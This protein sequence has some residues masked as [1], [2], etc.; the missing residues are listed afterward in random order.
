[1]D[2]KQITKVTQQL[3]AVIGEET[4]DKL[5][6]ETRYCEKKRLMTPLRM[7]L[8]VITCLGGRRVQF[9]ADLHR[10][11]NAL[12]GTD[13][14]Y[15]PFHN[16]LAKPSFPD[17]MK[18]V[19]QEAWTQWSRKVLSPA[20]EG[21]FSAFDQVVIQD[22]SSFAVKDSLRHIFPGRFYRTNQAAVELHVSL[23]LLTG[24]PLN[25]ALTEDTA[26]ERA[27]QPE[28]ASLMNCLYL[29][30]RGYFEKRNLKNINDAGGFYIVR[31]P[32]SLNPRIISA[33][34]ADGTRLPR[35]HG[36]KLK[37]VRYDLRGFP[38]VD[39]LVE[40]GPKK[41]PFRCRLV[42]TWNPKHHQFQYLATNLPIESYDASFIQEGYRLRWQ[43]ELLFK[44]RKSHANLHVFN[45]SK[46]PIAKGLIWASL[47]A[48]AL[49]R[50]MAH[51]TQLITQVEISTQRAA[52]CAVHFVAEIA[53]AV[54]SGSA[55]R[56]YQAVESAIRLLSINAKRTHP[57][58]DRR[59]GRT[60]SGLLSEGVGP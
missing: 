13:V 36:K 39:L 32:V 30:D 24:M 9:L 35:L 7:V 16:R 18:A 47:I 31:A 11:F 46:A 28:P 26:P 25:V 27:Y 33:Q 40:W 55:P 6:R 4:H 44:E 48:A 37:T 51:S 53:H 22:G 23:E 29:A 60:S 17:F 59:K 45:T 10:Q 2:E 21:H 20:G 41:A 12:F 50:Y 38:S 57:K 14:A 49:S 52:M 15:K 54:R 1:M 58:R 56:L 43:I 3:Q 42:M 8:T 34:L 19:A 5:G